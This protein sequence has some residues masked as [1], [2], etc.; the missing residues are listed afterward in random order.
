MTLT[1]KNKKFRTLDWLSLIIHV[2][3]CLTLWFSYTYELFCIDFIKKTTNGYFFV[4]PIILL[5]VFY[6]NLRNLKYYVFWT[7]IGII[8]VIVYFIARDNPDFLFPRMTG[9]NSLKALLPVLIIFQILRQMSLKVYKREIIISL[10][11]RIS[12]Y[13]EE[14]KR[15]MTWMEV[16]FSLILLASSIFFSS[17]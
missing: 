13:E 5:G 4:L 7:I 11:H 16:L 2:L 9:L 14:E 8:Q 12:M 3:I 1:R 15:K 10:H 6:R 17:I